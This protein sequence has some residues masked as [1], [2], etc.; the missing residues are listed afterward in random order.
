MACDAIYG[1]INERLITA[2][3]RADANTAPVMAEAVYQELRKMA[4]EYGMNPDTE[5]HKREEKG[6]IRVS[7]EAGPYQWAIG[8]SL[9]LVIATGKLVE[10]YYS[11]DLCFY[12]GEDRV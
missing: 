10:P 2:I 1:I 12:P 8:T 3:A 5:V 11:F 7:W 9:A 6:E 4:A